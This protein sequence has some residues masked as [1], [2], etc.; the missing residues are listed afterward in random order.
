L[1]AGGVPSEEFL[2]FSKRLKNARH[3]WQ[4]VSLD[5][6]SSE[7]SVGEWQTKHL[8]LSGAGG[9]AGIWE[10]AGKPS[11]DPAEETA[12]ENAKGS[13]PAAGMPSPR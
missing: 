12:A 7:T 13:R 10:K 4:M 8:P 11:A 9:V 5:F 3:R 2:F 1:Q 6:T